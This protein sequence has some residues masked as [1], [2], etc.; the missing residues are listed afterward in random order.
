MIT[1]IGRYE[2][3]GKIAEGGMA[4]VYHA[5]DPNFE[6][7]VAI[8]IL[9]R[10]FLEDASFRLRFEREAKIIAQLEHPAIVPVYDFAEEEGQPYIVMRYMAGGS[11]KE[12]LD[13]GA[14]DLQETVRIVARIATALDAAH[15]HNIIHRD[16][17]PGNIL[18]DH[19]G[20]A[21]L[22]DFGIARL[23]ESGTTT[24][25]GAS[26]MG[27]PAYMS[28]EQIQGEK[29]I[30]GRSDVYAVGVL[31]YHMLA[32]N[33]PYFADSPTAVMM[34]HIS[35][36]APSLQL[37]RP[38]IPAELDV[39]IQKA[40]SKEREARFSTAGDFASTMNKAAQ[41]LGIPI[42]TEERANLRSSS[43][44]APHAVKTLV[45]D[46]EKIPPPP[47]ARSG[48]RPGTRTFTWVTLLITLAAL[49]AVGW[50][51]FRSLSGTLPAF[52][53]SRLVSST[54]SQSTQL[55]LDS[56]P[57][58]ETAPQRTITLTLFTNTTIEP[59]ATTTHTAPGASARETET[60]TPSLPPAAPI[61][62]GADKIAYLDQ[63]DIW[64]A[65]LDGSDLIRLTEDGS[66]KT[67]L[68]WSPDGTAVHYISGN[69]V[70][71]VRVEDGGIDTLICLNFVEY[72]KSFMISPDGTQV[73]LSLDNQL[74]IIPYNP[75]A[76]AQVRTRGDLSKMAACEHFAPY[77]AIFV[78]LVR[79]SADSRQLA[80]V[81]FGVASGIG[82]ADIIQVLP[83]DTCIP[84]PR[85]V[86]NFPPPRFR[87]PEY[88]KS[89]AIHNF[90]WD[91][92]FLFAFNT[93]VRSNGFGHLY[94]YN[95]DLHKAR[96]M[97]NPIEGKCCYRD[98]HWSPDGSYL[99][100]AFQDMQ[101]GA[102]SPILLY[103]I[104]YGS[105]GTGVSYTPLPL[106]AI[107]DPK[108]IP[109]PVLRL[110]LNLE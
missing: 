101:A 83:V 31:T 19:Y 56:S 35:Q 24:L 46:K 64:V 29:D 12:R 23:K 109:Y 7:D 10:A 75:E 72:F 70:Y 86:D 73:A 39:C 43:T 27:T 55:S 15:A 34:M 32:G 103:Y 60:P 108:E 89:P 5:F 26:L 42:Y 66:E 63:H 54:P 80:M 11:L 33:L 45:P 88:E 94:I 87:P 8:K 67:S 82:S 1:H 71:S 14:L 99:L 84:N 25:T 18:F 68:Q 65:N 48:F 74:Y 6:R 61:I 59:S 85:P 91:G 90:A 40:M 22:S 9:P 95:M 21:F 58:S 110:A 76:L 105:I 3:K 96:S 62:G 57:T 100:F 102:N 92:Y 16:I 36:S 77:E 53:V 50:F 47:T 52:L 49:C 98:A 79:W 17:K 106:P 2:I 28:P 20:N 41:G 4:T 13:Q 107:N 81:V 37:Y 69:C 38:D 44:I 93:L 97:V 78:K 51:T 104:P 30:D